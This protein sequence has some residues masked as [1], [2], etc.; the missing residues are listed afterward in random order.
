MIKLLVLAAALALPLSGFAADT[1]AAGAPAPAASAA[2]PIPQTKGF[3]EKSQHARVKSLQ[4]T[5]NKRADAQK[6]AGEA[7]KA[8]VA[9]CVTGK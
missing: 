3:D 1:A 5:C 4:A 7:R 2:S 9:R 6:L 8:F